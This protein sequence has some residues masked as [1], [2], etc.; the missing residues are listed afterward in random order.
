LVFF[1]FDTNHPAINTEA[2]VI[3]LAIAMRL[4]VVVGGTVA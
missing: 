2:K 3:P 4:T 1:H